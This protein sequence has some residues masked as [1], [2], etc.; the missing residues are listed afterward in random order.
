MQ[1]GDLVTADRDHLLPWLAWD[2]N[3]FL[4]TGALDK[5]RFV[6]LLS[7]CTHALCTILHI[8]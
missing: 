2:R 6:Q 1:P 7:L 3:S 4:D 5:H 8:L